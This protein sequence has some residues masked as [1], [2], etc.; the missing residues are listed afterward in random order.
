M[1]KKFDPAP[2]DKHAVS[3][4]EAAKLDRE[5]SN[6]LQKGLEDSFP[7]SDPVSLTQP[8]PS[9]HDSNEKQHKASIANRDHHP[10]MMAHGTEEQG[11]NQKG[12]SG[13]RIAEGRTPPRTA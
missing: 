3:P 12:D 1:T 4:K 5:A 13:A 8:A 10:G 2:F 11:L 7:A 6:N 9:K